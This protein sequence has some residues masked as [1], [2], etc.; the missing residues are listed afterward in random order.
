MIYARILTRKI[1]G[2]HLLI[3]KVQCRAKSAVSYP[4]E[5]NETKDANNEVQYTQPIK[6]IPGPKA[7]PLLDNWFRFLS[8]I[9]KRFCHESGFKTR[10]KIFIDT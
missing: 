8:N 3:S 7:L 10:G 5:Y 6:D 2:W 9:G 1:N 4:I